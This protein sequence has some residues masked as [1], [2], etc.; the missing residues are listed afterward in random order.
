MKSISYPVVEDGEPYFDD[1]CPI[2][3]D[4]DEGQFLEEDDGQFLDDFGEDPD[5]DPEE[6]LKQYNAEEAEAKFRMKLREFRD[7]HGANSIGV[8]PTLPHVQACLLWP[9]PLVNP[10][11]NFL[12]I[13]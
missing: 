9:C 4:D 10:L 6:E 1:D 13:F 7:L 8:S 11:T 5:P 2:L 12:E 3:G